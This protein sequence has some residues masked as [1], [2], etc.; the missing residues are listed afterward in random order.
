M[1]KIILHF[2]FL[3]LVYIFGEN[4]TFYSL[5]ALTFYLYT[6]LLVKHK[7]CE[8]LHNNSLISDFVKLNA[9][10]IVATL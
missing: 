6:L 10:K 3:H 9:R 2:Y 4:I 1:I 5:N 8:D 7:L